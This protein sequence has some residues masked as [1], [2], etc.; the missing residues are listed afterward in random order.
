MAA[1]SLPFLFSFCTFVRAN[2]IKHESVLAG[3]RVVKIRTWYDPGRKSSLFED[4]QF[5]DRSGGIC[6]SLIKKQVTQGIKHQCCTT[7]DRFQFLACSMA[8]RPDHE[9]NATS[10]KFL[11]DAFL[12]FP[13]HR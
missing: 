2:R 9:A 10:G 4:P 11:G 8:M 12:L 5:Y 6:A 13:G 7:G 1:R 3:R